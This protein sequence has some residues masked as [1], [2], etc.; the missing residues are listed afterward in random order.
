MKKSTTQ[1]LNAAIPV[2]VFA[3]L[4]AVGVIGRFV[5]RESWPNFTPTAA[6][7][8]FA[9]FY[10]ARGWTAALVPMCVMALSNLWL[11]VYQSPAEVVVVYLAVLLPVA[12]GRLVKRG[13]SVQGFCLLALVPSLV[14]Y[15]TT[16]LAVWCCTPMY[17]HTW[18]GFVRC[19]YV[20]LPFYRWMLEGDVVFLAMTFGAYAAVRWLSSGSALPILQVPTWTEVARLVKP[21]PAVVPARR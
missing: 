15:L 20:A 1:K 18:A 14:F 2:I 4:V 5:F 12:I 17:S 19:Y 3:L 6:V 13:P 11:P 10:F 9:G 16:N 8:L 7:A 21:Q